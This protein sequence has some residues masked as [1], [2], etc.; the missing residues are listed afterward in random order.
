MDDVDDTDDGATRG[1]GDAAA[2]GT[3]ALFGDVD[4]ATA[5]SASC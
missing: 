4:S 1:D 3:D 2:A 5:T